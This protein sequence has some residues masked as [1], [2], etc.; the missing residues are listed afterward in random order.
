MEEWWKTLKAFGLLFRKGPALPPGLV[1]MPLIVAGVWPL[2]VI[3]S[4]DPRA[5]F[6][7]T[8]VITMA[9]RFALGAERIIE[10]LSRLV[11]PRTAAIVL[12]MCGPG[13]MALLIWSGEP[14]WCQRFLSLYFGLMTLAYLVDVMTGEPGVLTVHFARRLH[15]V[16]AVLLARMMV[17]YHLAMLL[18]NE[19]LIA[20]AGLGAWLV[21][22]ALLPQISQRMALAL[23]RTAHPMPAE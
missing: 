18:L 12:L 5:A 14:L 7:L 1:V 22:F 8:F 17:L 3:A 16:P 2:A 23:V 6:M 20:H 13:I 19:T 11:E 9:L 15:R 4:G 21:F 10:K